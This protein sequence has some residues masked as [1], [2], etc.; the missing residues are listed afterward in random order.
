MKI[1]WFGFSCFLIEDS[2]GNKILTDPYNYDIIHKILKEK[3]DIITLSHKNF[4]YK[5]QSDIR[6]KVLDSSGIFNLSNITIEGFPSYRDK[7]NGFKRGENIIFTFK[8]DNYRICHLGS[9]GYV[10]SKEELD[11]LGNIDVL[12][13][14]V[15][16]NFTINY[17]EA[18]DLCK[19]IN[20]KIIIPMN[21]NAHKLNFNLHGTESFIKE[22]KNAEKI[23]TSPFE[24]NEILT[25]INK[26]IILNEKNLSAMFIN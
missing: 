12:F 19:Q 6:N 2:N 13:V 1:T 22:I 3:I 11:R 4:N 17:R 15:G 14:P 9:L 21:Y 26:I 8:I 5:V 7:F 10:L 18:A 20:S 16:G 24:I 25:S 23:S